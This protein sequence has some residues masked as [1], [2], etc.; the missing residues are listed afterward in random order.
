MNG[1]IAF[2]PEMVNQETIV[3]A[4][5]LKPSVHTPCRQAGHGPPVALNPDSSKSGQDSPRMEKV[6][7]ALSVQGYKPLLI[8]LRKT[9]RRRAG[10]CCRWRSCKASRSTVA[11]ALELLLAVRHLKIR[12]CSVLSFGEAWFEQVC[13]LTGIVE[14]HKAASIKRLPYFLIELG[15]S[16]LLPPA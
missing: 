14:L 15:G 16:V 10:G 13:A 3:S 7:A 9:C 8:D 6:I 4:H 11:T 12:F 2:D 5:R 1:C